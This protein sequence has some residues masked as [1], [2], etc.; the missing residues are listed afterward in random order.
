MQAEDLLDVLLSS[1]LEE[2]VDV[3]DAELVPLVSSARALRPL[4]SANPDS[5]FAVALEGRLLARAAARHAEASVPASMQSPESTA[6]IW[7]VPGSRRHTSRRF[8]PYWRAAAAAIVL[9]FV[10]AGTLTVAAHAGPGGPL[11]GLRRFE[12]DVQVSLTASAAGRVQLHIT[13]ANDALSALTGAAHRHDMPAY[14]DALNTL[15]EETTAAAQALANMPESASR[16]ALEASL[17]SLREA[18]R[19]SLR[20]SLSG[21][22]WPERVAATAALGDLGEAIPQVTGVTIAYAGDSRVAQ[23]QV[24]MHGSGFEPGALLTFD[25]STVGKVVAVSSNMLTAE[26]NLARG[27][28]LPGQVGVENPDGT[29]A[30]TSTIAIVSEPF[31]P[32]TPEG[33]ATP[34]SE[35]KSGSSDTRAGNQSGSTSTSKD[36]SHEPTPVASPEATHTPGTNR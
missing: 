14:D 18:E 2:D 24:T 30:S 5:D 32:E 22:S 7:P 34:G 35:G 4:R 9:V 28:G 10:G 17:S 23:S 29:A 13:F 19:Q 25:G 36:K 3:A 31:G 21:L 26:V 6:G 12:Q 8:I 15:N 20:A 11:Y 33:S 27:A 16:N 1:A